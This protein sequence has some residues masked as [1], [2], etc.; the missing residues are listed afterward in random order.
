MLDG[1][2]VAGVDATQAWHV[3]R[4]NEGPMNYLDTGTQSS[5]HH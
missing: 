2:Q 5:F 3:Q 4:C 1:E